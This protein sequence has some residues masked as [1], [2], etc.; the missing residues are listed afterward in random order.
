MTF[1]EQMYRS[2]PKQLCSVWPMQPA[3]A[4][5]GC[6]WCLPSAVAEA[7]S[8]TFTIC[9][10]AQSC[11]IP[12][13]CLTALTTFVSTVILLDNGCATSLLQARSMQTVQTNLLDSITR[14]PFL[15]YPFASCKGALKRK[16]LYFTL[17]SWMSMQLFNN[18]KH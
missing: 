16:P 12:T 1:F 14:A 18:K 13:P 8:T 7:R 5:A 17:S 6:A 4:V 3:C 15:P 2:W 11:V 9:L 10:L